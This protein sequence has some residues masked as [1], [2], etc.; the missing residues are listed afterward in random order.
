MVA[1]RSSKLALKQT[2]IVLD[3][4]ARFLPIDRF[5]IIS[6]KTKGDL[7]HRPLFS[8]D[9]KGLFEKE[10]NDSVLTG[11][12]DFGVH[13]LKD[14]P[15]DLDPDLFIAAILRRAKPN[16]V[17]VSKKKIKLAALP[18]GSKVGTSSLRRAIQV[19]HKNPGLDV[20]PIRGNVET[21][22]N[23]SLSGI[24]DAVVLA[25]AGLIRLGMQDVIIERLDLKEFLPA[26]GQGAM[27]IICRRD[28]KPIVTLLQKIEHGPS[29]NCIEAERALMSGIEAGC[30]FPIGAL[31]QYSK[32]SKTIQL[33][34]KALSTDGKKSLNVEITG[35]P[36]K[37]A[38]IGYEA[39]RWLIRNGI[40]EIATGWRDALDSWN[41]I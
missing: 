41:K 19:L 14:I 25:E 18:E 29:R 39:S 30:R 28:N 32:R 7:D 17:L 5:K 15:T 34:V 24:F 21:R 33:R 38:E 22:I 6:I 16:D 2:E 40:E 20:V 10:V 26:P 9:R 31:A 23:K 3:A 1:S 13:S 12:A 36:S 11:N 4:L 27:A 35:K 37:P 8:M